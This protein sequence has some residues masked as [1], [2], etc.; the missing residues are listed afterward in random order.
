MGIF[1]SVQ[2]FLIFFY[3]NN[4]PKMFTSCN[5]EL[6][7]IEDFRTY[8]REKAVNESSLLEL[9]KILLKCFNCDDLEEKIR[10]LVPYVDKFRLRKSQILKL[11][12][13]FCVSCFFY[14]PSGFA[15][16]IKKNPELFETE[17]PIFFKFL[18]IFKILKYIW[19]NS[20]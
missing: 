6:M 20:K 8:V 16:W 15:T 10:V 17:I 7:K 11:S 4:K 2:Y 12:H 18:L 5:P 13:V 14:K 3:K 9:L 1:T 19:F